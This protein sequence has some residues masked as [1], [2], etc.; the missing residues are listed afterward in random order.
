MGRRRRNPASSAAA[1]VSSSSRI[2]KSE[3]PTACRAKC[4][5][6]SNALQNDCC[7]GAPASPPLLPGLSLA[8]QPPPSSASSTKRCCHARHAFVSQAL[9]GRRWI[10][11]AACAMQGRAHDPATDT[12]LR[13]SHARPGP[14]IRILT[15]QQCA[16]QPDAAQGLSV[17]ACAARQCPP[18]CASDASRHDPC[19]SRQPA[20]HS[21][22]LRRN[23]NSQHREPGV[24]SLRV[25]ACCLG[26]SCCS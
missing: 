7:R 26:S 4:K 9:A 22:Q 21:R 5:L 25:W 20:T 13:S 14:P 18:S 10:Q 12:P 19:A 24:L 8:A 2:C 6:F 15:K 11:V 16:T 17:L 1:H 3:I 23:C